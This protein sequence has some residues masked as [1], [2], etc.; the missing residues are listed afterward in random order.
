VPKIGAVEKA[1]RDRAII[2][3]LAKLF[4][5]RREVEILGVRYTRASLAAKF[6]KHLRS[7]ARVQELTI[8]RR[9]A[10]R[11]EREQE[12]LL[13]PFID[14]IKTL[15]AV[16][17]G[18]ARDARMRSYGFEPDKKPYMSAQRKLA[19]NVKRQETRRKRGLVSKKKR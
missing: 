15:A 16:A 9:E 2:R 7:M 12:A 10:I 1:T 18:G 4:E 13:H 14:A 17:T 19:A 6:E 11:E 5:G 3:G 8:A